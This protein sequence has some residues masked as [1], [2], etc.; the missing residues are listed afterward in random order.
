[1]AIREI[2]YP[3]DLSECA[4]YAGGYAA[5]LAHTLGASLHILHVPFVPSPLREGEWA[6]AIYGELARS[7]LAEVQRLLHEAEFRGLQVRTT[8]VG[9]LI[10][11]EIRK[12]AEK[13]DLIV[14]GTHGRTGLSRT[15]LG[16]VT[17]KVIGTARRPVLVVKHPDIDI[18]LPWG[19]YL[20]R[21]R[22]TQQVPPRFLNILVPLDGSPRSEMV[23][24]EATDLA[25]AFEAVII[26]FLV[27][28][29]SLHLGAKPQGEP[30][31]DDQV[32]GVDYLRGKQQALY[33]EGLMVET[34]LRMGDAA[35][36]ILD[37]AD[38]RSIDLIAM[39]THGWT[40]LKRWLLGSV[41]EKVLRASNIPVLMIRG[42]REAT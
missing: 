42:W 8:V 25:R 9:G 12:A 23:L 7:G 39:A 19:E 16:S 33:R 28:S 27:I 35:L 38:E 4:R 13:S 22:R 5:G 37:Y 41:A 31:P 20:K 1:M 29:P 6:D 10:E 15:M 18:E 30:S 36:E 3:T 32:K 24:D 14:M 2:L 40:G 34:V 21:A 26:L 11:E 17:E